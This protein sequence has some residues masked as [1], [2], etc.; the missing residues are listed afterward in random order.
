MSDSMALASTAL[1]SAFFAASLGE[2]SDCNPVVSWNGKFATFILF[3][4]FFTMLCWFLG[5]VT[6]AKET[7]YR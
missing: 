3:S 2:E 5:E 6:F 7:E 4:S 1:A